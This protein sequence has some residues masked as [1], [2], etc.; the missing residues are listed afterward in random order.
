[1]LLSGVKP[2]DYIC[3]LAYM[4]RNPATQPELQ[5]LR[6]VLRDRYLLP[7]MLGFGPRYLHS[8][9]QLHKGGPNSGV[10][11]LITDAANRDAPIPGASLHLR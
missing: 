6:L 5:A 8:T 2:G 4:P 11:I 3:I 10:F 9:G 7:T 1:M